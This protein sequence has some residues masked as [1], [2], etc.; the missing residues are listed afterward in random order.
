L[1]CE[2]FGGNPVKEIIL[3]EMYNHLTQTVIRLVRVVIIERDKNFGL[4][5]LL[6]FDVETK[7]VIEWKYWS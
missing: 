7:Y 4:R 1:N 5:D 3:L 6:Y 2:P